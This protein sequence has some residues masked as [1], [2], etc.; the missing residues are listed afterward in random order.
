MT[1]R[2]ALLDLPQAHVRALDFLLRRVPPPAHTWALTGSAGLRL[3]GVDVPVHDLDIQADERTIYLMEKQLAKFMQT[4]VHR[5]DSISMRSLDG[6]AKS[7]LL[8]LNSWRIYP[9][10][11]RMALGVL[12]P[13]SPA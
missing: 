11:N 3:Q 10:A 6:R 5:W 13:I 2:S 8:K 7:R 9:I 4:L 1:E 12:S